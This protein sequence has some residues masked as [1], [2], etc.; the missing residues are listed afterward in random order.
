MNKK[1]PTS[2]NYKKERAAGPFWISGRNAV[3][4]ALRA[5]LPA[6]TLYLREKGRGQVIDL[7]KKQTWKNRLRWQEVSS[8]TIDRLMR[9]KDH[10]GV[11]LE[12]EELAIP[13][14]EDWLKDQNDAEGKIQNQF[15][16]LL[17]GIQ[18]PQNLG[19]VIRSAEGFGV[20]AVILPD[21]AIAPLGDAAFRAS[22]G[23]LAWQKIVRVDSIETALPQLSKAGFSCVGLEEKSGTGLRDT[24]LEFPLAVVLGGEGR[25][26][27]QKVQELLDHKVE[28]MMHGHIGSFNASVAAGI[29][30]HHF[31]IGR[32]QSDV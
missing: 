16:L 31:S 21:S 10:R 17:D 9:H 25:G 3:L 13:V 20:D 5:E 1:Y 24:N 11:A 18:D 4:E 28:I 23:A 19:A 29:V 32:V 2:K 12:L 8:G 15:V 26:L 22:A 6:R 27:S 14:F 30:L 7:I